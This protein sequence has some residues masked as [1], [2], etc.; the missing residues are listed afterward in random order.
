MQQV[1]IHEAKAQLPKLI[2]R[3]IAG[4]RVVIAKRNVPLVTIQPIVGKKGLRKLGQYKH[5][6]DVPASFFEPLPEHI[7]DVFKCGFSMGNSSE[8]PTGEI[9]TS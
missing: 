3:A 6:I 5:T 9:A 1:N 8:I 2:M 7:I 4:E